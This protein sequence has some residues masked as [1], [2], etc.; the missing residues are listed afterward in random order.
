MTTQQNVNVP[1]DTTPE[2]L[3]QWRDQLSRQNPD[4]APVHGKHTVA[5]KAEVVMQGGRVTHLAEQAKTQG[6]NEAYVNQPK[7][8]FVTIGG[9]ETPVAAAKAAGLLPNHWQEGQPVPFADPAAA[10]K[11][12]KAGTHSGA[13]AEQKQEVDASTAHAQHLAKIA[14][15]ILQGVQQ[16]HG[17]GAAEPLLSE[18]A[19][20]GD[21]DSVLNNL[22]QGVT[23][24]HAKQ[25]YAGFRAAADHAFA[26]GGSSLAAVEELLNDAEL[27]DAR[28]FTLANNPE[29][30]A[31]LGRVAAERL[32]QL[33]EVEARAWIAELPAKERGYFAFNKDRGVTF[34]APGLP[35][36]SW[37]AAVRAGYVKV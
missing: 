7:P 35:E 21:L 33:P 1:T 29:A 5:S 8:G 9:V 17:P 34:K 11:E 2:Q 23:E 10:P 20:S 22:P 25:V 18:V 15:D 31:N 3:Q 36:M 4:A 32:A 27:R 37:G 24:T 16:I 28:R 26:Q 30:L 6:Y 13:E 12:V 19:E 14:G